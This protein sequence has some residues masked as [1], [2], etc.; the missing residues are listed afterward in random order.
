[1]GSHPGFN[2]PTTTN[3]LGNVEI[4]NMN[5]EG[6]LMNEKLKLMPQPAAKLDCPPAK[7]NP[8]TPVEAAALLHMDHRTL[9]RWARVGYTPAHPLGEGHR[10][11]WRFFEDE[12]LAW[13]KS[14]SNERTS[15]LR[16]AA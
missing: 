12:L 11:M 15:V 8:L 7:R 2:R 9:I 4:T 6:T 10:R 14:Q 1:M 16:V 13:V 5:R 3:E